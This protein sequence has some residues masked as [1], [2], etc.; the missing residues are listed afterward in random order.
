MAN[1]QIMPQ[2][3]RIDLDPIGLRRQEDE[4]VGTAA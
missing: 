1:S 2:I 4:R 3:P